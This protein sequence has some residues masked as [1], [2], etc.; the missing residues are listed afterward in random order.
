M[1]SGCFQLSDAL[2][3]TNFSNK[4]K[5]GKPKVCCRGHWKPS[6]DA[7]LRELVAMH[8]PQNWNLIAQKLQ[9]RSGKSCRL[10]WYNQL[11][12][13]INRGAFS[14]EEEKTLMEAQREY[15]NKWALISK[16]FPGRTDNAVK[17]HWHVVTARKYREFSKSCIKRKWSTHSALY[18]QQLVTLMDIHEYSK[19][20]TVNAPT[21]GSFVSTKY[22]DPAGVHI[23]ESNHA[24]RP[25]SK[26]PGWV[27][28]RWPQQGEK[29]QNHI[30]VSSLSEISFAQP[31][32]Q[33]SDQCRLQNGI[34][35]TPFFIDFLGVGTS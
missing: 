34:T 35:A 5:N 13:N 18:N 31:L 28:R 15:G 29:I 21:P 19:S 10:R 1:R 24:I 8:G 26:F 7:K 23:L 32:L 3:S 14:E 4:P 12:P 17:N 2:R 6:E 27:E 16:L 30:S 25:L 11:N 33:L 22:I 9:G 20:S